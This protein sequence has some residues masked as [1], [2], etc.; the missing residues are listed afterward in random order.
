MHH[1]STTSDPLHRW[2]INSAIIRDLVG[3]RNENVR[4]YLKTRAA[5]IEAHHKEFDPEL[6]AKQNNKNMNIK[7]ERDLVALL[8]G[9]A[10]VTSQ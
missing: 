4:D 3:G 7:Q 1:K 10:P 8:H 2:F 6:T 9:D 5:E